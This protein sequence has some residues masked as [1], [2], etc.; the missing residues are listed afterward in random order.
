[1]RCVEISF[2]AISLIC[3]APAKVFWMRDGN[4]EMETSF[5]ELMDI[6]WWERRQLKLDLG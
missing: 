4:M 3:S 2:P 1:M 6:E 5:K